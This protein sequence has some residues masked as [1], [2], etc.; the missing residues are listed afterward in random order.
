MS[1]KQTH[2]KDDRVAFAVAGFV[3]VAA[4]GIAML[5]GLASRGGGGDET[6]SVPT[7]REIF[8]ASDAARKQPPVQL[9]SLTSEA[10][11]PIEAEPFVIEAIDESVGIEIDADFM[12]VGLEA[13]REKDYARAA[14]Y[15][16][17]EAEARPQRPWTHYIHGLSLW[18]NGQADEAAEALRRSIELDPGQV[19]SYVNLSRIENERDEYD[20]A[21]LAAEGA[22]AV[23]PENAEAL[24]VKA[25]SLYNAE[26]RESAL[27][28]LERSVEIDA[29][30]GFAHNLIGLIAI[31]RGDAEVATV[32]TRRAAELQPEVV[33]I[34]NNLGMAL[35]LGGDLEGAAVAYARAIAIDPGHEKA[36]L[37]LVRLEGHL[38]VED[39]E[40]ATTA[41]A[42]L[43]AT[44]P[45]QEESDGFPE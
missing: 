41:V 8:D 17:A 4:I 34:Q 35:E 13:W 24:F 39:E 16:G 2:T 20:A 29:D 36:T 44:G 12:A 5:A 33:F 43:E 23:E 14:A 1:P 19:K 26:D 40:T 9:A 18:K 31:H 27:A 10:S 21:L 25:R 7:T 11:M 15:F 38:P 30:N 22:L 3:V 42:L 28:A 32:A 45:E 6:A 37:N